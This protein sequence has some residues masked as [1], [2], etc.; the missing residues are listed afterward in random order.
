MTE[1][2]GD[3]DR[4]TK[5]KRASAPS[6]SEIRESRVQFV[7]CAPAQKTPAIPRGIAMIKSVPILPACPQR[8]PGKPP[9]PPS[10]GRARGKCE[11]RARSRLPVRGIDQRRRPREVPP[12][13]SRRI[14]AIARSSTSKRSVP[15]GTPRC[16]PLIDKTRTDVN[17]DTGFL[18]RLFRTAPFE[19]VPRPREP[20][21]SP[22]FVASA[23]SVPSRGTRA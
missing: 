13:G 19:S 9:P 18:H 7:P 8:A 20:P 17:A 12:F 11:R 22:R 5:M 10:S 2:R 23:N 1:Q 3:R 15:K 14:T 21:E 16:F 4:E 6:V